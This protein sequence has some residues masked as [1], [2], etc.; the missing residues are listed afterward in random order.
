M[1]KHINFEDNIF[2]LNARVRMIRDIL[3]LDADPG[4]FLEKTADDLEFLDQTLSSLLNGLLENSKFLE[5]DESFENISALEW[6][7]QQVL[8]EFMGNSG[9]ISAA[10]Y[11]LLRDRAAVYRGHS[12]ERQ[13]TAE[14]SVR[15]PE[16]VQMEPVVSTDELN[17]LLKDF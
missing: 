17:E 14:Q 5:R 7:F 13:K 1:N 4:L 9:G 11:P 6:Q 8:G 10:G 16:G 12:A 3:V 2:I 15:N